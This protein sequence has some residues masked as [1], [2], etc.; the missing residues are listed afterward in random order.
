VEPEPEMEA[1][2]PALADAIVRALIPPA[3]REAVIGDLWER[4]TSPSAFVFEAVRALP[5]LV[6]S[7]IRRTTNAPMV[8][9]AFLMLFAS[10]GGSP[11]LW[12]NAFIP[13]LAVLAAFLLR[14]VY[15]DLSLS[16]IRRAIGDGVAVV[17]CAVATQAVL[18]V[19]RPELLLTRWGVL[20][21]LLT[22]LALIAGRLAGPG[23]N[24]RP[25]LAAGSALSLDELR[26]EMRQV[27]RAAR[28]TRRVESA[29]G[30]FVIGA[31]IAGTVWAPQITAK[32]GFALMAAGAGFVVL[33]M[34]RH[35]LR[36]LPMD[37]GFDASRTVLRDALVRGEQLLRSVWLWYLLPLMIG[38]LVLIVGWSVDGRS[39]RSVLG[40]LAVFVIMS[41][42]VW[43]MNRDAAMRLARRIEALDKTDERE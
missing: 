25:S 41:A 39:F 27:E 31:G 42:L 29:A 19:A 3:C 36:P 6:F 8:A 18:A 2:P 33:Y 4:Y 20:T 30:V 21:G 13:A 35:A 10:F 11:R 7:R 37:L 15:Q 26:G 23:A 34:R 9:V 32:A 12:L 40:F 43:R 5:F 17:V 22:C 1:R 38:P 14:D 16:P 28:V 24:P